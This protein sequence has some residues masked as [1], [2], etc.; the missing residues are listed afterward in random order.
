MRTAPEADADIVGLR[1]AENQVGVV[2]A[3]FENPLAFL[4]PGTCGEDG[5][6][7]KNRQNADDHGGEE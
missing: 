1:H 6:K 3:G 4:R 5:N 7:G 2:R